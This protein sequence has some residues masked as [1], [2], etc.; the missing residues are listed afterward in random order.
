MHVFL[1]LE[2][3]KRS[4]PC[5]SESTQMLTQMF[6]H[7]NDEPMLFRIRHWSSV[8]MHVNCTQDFQIVQKISPNFQIVQ[9][10]TS[11]VPIVCAIL[12]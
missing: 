11:M 12:Y 3:P 4:K 2:K 6:R 1:S 5:L 9:N 7:A 8:C 10:I